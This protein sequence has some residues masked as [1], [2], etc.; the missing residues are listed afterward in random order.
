MSEDRFSLV[1]AGVG[2]EK[3]L[4]ASRQF[5]KDPI[6]LGPSRG[7]GEWLDGRTLD[8]EGDLETGG[9]C[10]SSLLHLVRRG[11]AV[12]DVSGAHRPPFFDQSRQGR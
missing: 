1:V 10:A 11:K 9:D 2:S 3:P 5:D 6:A 7:F 8:L 12:M 4:L